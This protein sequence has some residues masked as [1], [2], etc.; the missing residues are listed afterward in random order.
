VPC[1]QSLPESRH[2]RQQK[3]WRKAEDSVMPDHTME[4]V[5][6]R[7]VQALIH[8]VRRVP[9]TLHAVEFVEILLG[10]V[11]KVERFPAVRC[12][13]VRDKISDQ[14]N[15]CCRY[16]PLRCLRN[17]PPNQQD[18]RRHT[19]QRGR[20]LVA[21]NHAADRMSCTGMSWARSMS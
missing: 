3:D 18:E 11:I 12:Q 4:E 15:Q 9:V 6:E 5:S 21:A 16:K 2:D 10:S 1:Q 14:R 17:R 19:E 13:V 7:R 20:Q 8:A